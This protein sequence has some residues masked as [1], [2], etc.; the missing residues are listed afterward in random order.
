MRL[1]TSM[2]VLLLACNQGMLR[3][4]G[5]CSCLVRATH[6]NS[7]TTAVETVTA[8]RE[9]LHSRSSL[10]VTH[11]AGSNIHHTIRF[12]SYCQDMRFSCCN[13]IVNEDN[14]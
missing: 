9:M 4:T 5:I 8:S 12:I 3:D 14:K 11:E 13:S 6:S 7:E 2:L 1:L 10:K